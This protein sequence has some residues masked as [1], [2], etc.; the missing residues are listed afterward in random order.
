MVSTRKTRREVSAGGVVF[1]RLDAGTEVALI[2][3]ADV[4]GERVWALPKGLVE[5]RERTEEAA[6]REVREETGL[7]ATLVDNIG[8][9]NYWYF[10]KE[11][12]RIFKTVKFFLMEC[13]GGDTSNHDWEVA[14]V[15]WFP[16]DAAGVALAYKGEREIVQKAAEMLALI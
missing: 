9:V 16:I 3:R 6:L 11:K 14:E 1:R 12:V 8:E 7:D 5:R 4:H 15:R 10:S 13:T 2:G